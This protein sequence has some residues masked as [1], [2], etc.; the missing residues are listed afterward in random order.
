MSP[1]STSAQNDDD[2]DDDDDEED[3]G[4][5]KRKRDAKKG[6]LFFLYFQ[7]ATHKYSVELEFIGLTADN[8]AIMPSKD[9]ENYVKMK[10]VNSF[11]SFSILIVNDRKLSFFS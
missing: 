4:K 10:Q 7:F 1:S 9:F 3:N 6:Q 5:K 11:F 2:D 8:I